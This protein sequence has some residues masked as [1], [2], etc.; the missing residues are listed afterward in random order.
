MINWTFV[1]LGNL[2]MDTA[3]A[4]FAILSGLEAYYRRKYDKEE[5]DKIKESIKEGKNTH[6]KMKIS[7][8]SHYL[9]KADIYS[10]VSPGRFTVILLL[11]ATGIAFQII[12]IIGI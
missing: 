3:I 12:G 5:M 11:F 4:I 6:P 2:I 8:A 10:P 1:L 7:F 9:S